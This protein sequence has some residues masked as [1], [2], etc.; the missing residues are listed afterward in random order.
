MELESDVGRLVL[1]LANTI[2]KNRN[3]HLEVLGL[4]ASQADSMKFFLANEWATIKD[5]KAHLGTT[6]QTAQGIVSRLA[7]KGFLTLEK[8]Q[9]DRRCQKIIPTEYGRSLLEKLTAN[10]IRTGGLLLRGMTQ[11]EQAAFV[12]LLE[13]AYENVKYDGEV[14]PG[15]VRY[16]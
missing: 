14:K 3:R 16:L 8:S 1:K 9:E 15:D 2:I 5:L 12:S 4:T 11:E 13:I 7:E 6:H 10:C